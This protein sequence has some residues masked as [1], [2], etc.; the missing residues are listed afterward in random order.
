MARQFGIITNLEGLQAGIVV[1]SLTYNE[2]CET[3]EARNEKGQITDLASYSRST[4]LS[5]DGL[6]D[7]TEGV[8]L[9]KAG[10]KITIANKDYLIES[11]DKTESN[12]DFVQ[13]SISARTSDEATIHV[14]DAETDVP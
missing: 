6:L 14:I 9:V 11:V 12:T 1:N 8:N 13:V 3:A 5:I 2:A 7:T 10:N 4:T